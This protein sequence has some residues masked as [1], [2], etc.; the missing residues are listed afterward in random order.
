MKQLAW[1][2]GFALLA[3][4]CAKDTDLMPELAVQTDESGSVTSRADAHTGGIATVVYK[5][6]GENFSNLDQKVKMEDIAPSTYTA[7]KVGLVGTN[8]VAE[9]GLLTN[10]DPFFGEFSNDGTAI[11]GLGGKFLQAIFYI[12]EGHTYRFRIVKADNNADGQAWSASIKDLSTGVETQLGKLRSAQGSALRNNSTVQQ[13]YMGDKMPCS[14]VPR[15]TIS[16][17][18][19]A[20]DLNSETGIYRATSRYSALQKGTCVEASVQ[21][22]TV[23]GTPKVPLLLFGTD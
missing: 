23:D 7:M 9:I 5:W 12:E 13:E 10:S 6:D 17:F 2:L 16:A 18:P 11:F 1:A 15:S 19:P 20:A 4:A 22:L 3:A 14:A 21:L 8:Q